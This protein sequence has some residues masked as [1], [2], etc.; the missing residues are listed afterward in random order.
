[1]GLPSDCW[2][3]ALLWTSLLYR[4]WYIVVSLSSDKCTYC[5]SFWIKVAANAL[6][7]NVYQLTCSRDEL[8]VVLVNQ[9]LHVAVQ[10]TDLLHHAALLIHQLPQ[11]TLSPELEPSHTYH[12]ITEEHWAGTITHI[13]LHHRKTLGRNRHTHITTLHPPPGT[14]SVQNLVWC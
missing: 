9:R 2:C 14:H 1:M 11:R 7:V 13:S 4:R 6:K 3:L 5:K 12:Y 8:V 10:R